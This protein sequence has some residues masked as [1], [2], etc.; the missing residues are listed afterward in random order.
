MIFM[1]SAISAANEL[2]FGK[3]LSFSRQQG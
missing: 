3:K 1:F 2:I